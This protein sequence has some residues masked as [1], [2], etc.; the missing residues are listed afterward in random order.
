MLP[1]L[2]WMGYSGLLQGRCEN[3]LLGKSLTRRG[4]HVLG[5]SSLFSG[6]GRRTTKVRH[7]VWKLLKMSHWI[8]LKIL[9]FST[10]FCPNKTDLSGNTVWPQAS[11]FQKLAK[12]TIFGIFNELLSTQNVN[13]A[14]FARNVEWDFFCDFQT[15]CINSIFQ[16]ASEATF[17]HLKCIWIFPPKI[18]NSLYFWR[19]NSKL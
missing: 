8:S 11:G 4:D 1:T 3:A 9:A 12:L 17:K 16:D 14:R 10:N 6:G 15:A 18:N 2:D 19:E 13:V 5:H 7:I